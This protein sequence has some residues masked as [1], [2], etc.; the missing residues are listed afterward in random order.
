LI[1]LGDNCGGTGESAQ[2][3]G[4]CNPGTSIGQAIQAINPNAGFM[5]HSCPGCN[6][7]FGP[8]GEYD[9]RFTYNPT[10]ITREVRKLSP[11]KCVQRTRLFVCQDVKVLWTGKFLNKSAT[12]CIISLKGVLTGTSRHSFGCDWMRKCHSQGRT[13]MQTFEDGRS[14]YQQYVFENSEEGKT[15]A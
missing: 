1:S 7:E 2:N 10:N 11:L 12:I 15:A 14:L 13:P 4:R 3:H 5:I 8:N 9:F 6:Y